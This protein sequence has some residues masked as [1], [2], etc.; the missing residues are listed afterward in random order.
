MKYYSVSVI[1]HNHTI[2]LG[3][4]LASCDIEACTLAKYDHPTYLNFIIT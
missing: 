4:Y 1:I 2:F 3:Y